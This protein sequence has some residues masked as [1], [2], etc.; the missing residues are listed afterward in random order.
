MAERSR[1]TWLVAAAAVAVIIGV[2]AYVLWQRDTSGTPVP[3]IGG[4]GKSTT[5][6]LTAA[7]V[8]AGR[9]LPPTARPLRGAD[10]AFDGVVTR[11]V[12]GTATL[13]PSRWYAGEPTRQV[14]VRAP[15][16]DMQ[17]LLAAVRFEEG[18]RYLVAASADGRVMLCGFSAPYSERLA[19]LYRT[20][21][22]G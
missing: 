7:P 1:L 14:T 22:E 18:E 12:D 6:V 9:C 17:A 5:T 8:Q 3:P 20:A 10:V 13:E 11:L 2:G 16:E 4:T 19:R 21:F 15:S